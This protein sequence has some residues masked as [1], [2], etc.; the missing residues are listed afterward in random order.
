[1]SLT[2]K[3]NLICNFCKN[4]FTTR[5]QDVINSGLC[6]DCFIAKNEIIPHI[7]AE[8]V[9]IKNNIFQRILEREK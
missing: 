9:E 3:P 7:P 2:E 8:P 5:R 1:M 6:P 4:R